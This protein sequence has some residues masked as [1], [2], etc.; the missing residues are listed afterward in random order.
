MMLD[1]CRNASRCGL[2]LT[3]VATGGGE[4]EDDF[5]ES[6]VPFIRLSRALP[7]D[8]SLVAQLRKIIEERDIQ[9]VHGHQPI[10]GLHLYLATRHSRVKRVL[11][12]HG[13]YPGAKNEL[14]LKFIT[15]RLHARV[16]VSN[17]LLSRLQEKG[18]DRNRNTIVIRNGVDPARLKTSAAGLREELGI[19]ND[20]LLMGMVANFHPVAQKDQL[21]VCKALPRMFPS[22]PN[23]R[24]IFIGGRSESA[25]RLFDECVDYCRKE[26]LGDR[27]RFLGK[28]TDIPRVLSSLDIFVL[29][30]LREGSPI[31]VIE[32]MMMGVPTVLSDIPALREVSNEGEYTAFFRVGDPTTLAERLIEICEDADQRASLASRARAWAN[33]EFSIDQHIANLIKLYESLCNES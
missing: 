30:T 33:K 15:P 28:R 10:D 9:V 25:P 2:D 19:G 18:I 1:V 27:V 6:G 31:S 4:L 22:V 26:N 29:S 8:L 21:T 3:F 12:I 16:L 7:I 17:D 32:A 5:R 23:A 11:T 24:F 14:A 13:F 20:E